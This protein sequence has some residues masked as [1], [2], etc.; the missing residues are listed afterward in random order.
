VNDN[1]AGMCEKDDVYEVVGGDIGINYCDSTMHAAAHGNNGTKL[2]ALLVS[3][4][5]MMFEI[6]FVDYR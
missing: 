5:T 1:A 2:L 3:S 4:I 6:K